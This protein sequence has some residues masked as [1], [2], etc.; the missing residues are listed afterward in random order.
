MFFVDKNW[1]MFE[2]CYDFS[3]V[4]VALLYAMLG[5]KLVRLQAPVEAVGGVVR[6]KMV[7]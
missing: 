4:A 7:I 2:Y 5:N 3:C 6:Q 1:S